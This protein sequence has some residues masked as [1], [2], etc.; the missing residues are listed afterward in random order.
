VRNIRKHAE[1]PFNLMKN[2][3][4]GAGKLNNVPPTKKSPKQTLVPPVRKCRVGHD[5]IVHLSVALQRHTPPSSNQYGTH[6]LKQ[7][8]A[9]FHDFP[10]CLLFFPLKPFQGCVT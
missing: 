10:T 3:G 4:Y 9:V 2:R 7:L 5:K 6:L 8:L 1:R